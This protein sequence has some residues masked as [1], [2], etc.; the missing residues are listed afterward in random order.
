MKTIHKE[1]APTPFEANNDRNNYTI[2]SMIKQSLNI[3][4]IVLVPG[5]YQLDRSNL[6]GFIAIL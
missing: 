1:Q 4:I 5:Y 3:N 6:S 2:T